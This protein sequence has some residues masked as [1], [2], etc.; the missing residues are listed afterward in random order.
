M[1]L[2]FTNGR[3]LLMLGL[4]T[5]APLFRPAAAQNAPA[6]AEVAKPNRGTG[7][8]T[9]TV[10]N[11]AT[12]QPV[13][14]ANVGLIDVATNK[15]I[16]GG[17]CDEKGR[18]I[19]SNIGAG[20]YKLNV[21][22]VGF[23]AKVMEH[24]VFATADANVDLGNIS[25]AA[26]AQQ[27]S[28][29]KVVGEREL[30]E[31]KIDRIV[32]NADKD[33]TNNGGTAADVL[34]K[35]PLLSVDIDGNLQLRGSGNIRVLVNGKPSTILANNLAD[36]LRQ[37]PADQIKSV[38][39]ITSPSSKYD[40]EGTAGVVNIILKKSNL[41]GVNGSVNG[42]ASNRG[43]FLSSTV[44][45]RRGKLGLNTN[46]GTNMF[47]NV[48]RNASVRTEFLPTEGRSTLQQSGNFTNLG[49]GAFAQLGIEYDLT[50]KDAFNI[51]GRGNLFGYTNDRNQRT[52]YIGPKVN[53]IFTRDIVTQ[54]QN[55]NFDLNFGYTRTM[56]KP[57][58]ELSVLALYSQN[59]GN[60]D[61]DLDQRR[62][63]FIDYHE[64]SSNDNR[65]REATLQLDYIQPVDS[66]GTLELGLKSILRRVSS[67]YL[68]ASD[69]LDGRGL[70]PIP[71]RSNAFRYDQNVY[72]TYAT[73]SFALG[74][75]LT[76]KAGTRVEH[77]RIDGDFITD[78]I[79]LR[80]DYTNVVPS[81][82][83]AY[84]LNKDNKLK[85]SYTRRIQRPGIWFLNPYVNLS[86][87]R[88]ISSGNPK[89]DPELTDAYEL[90]YSTFI[91]KSTI[92][93]SGYFRQTNNAIESVSRL[94]PSNTVLPTDDTTRVLYS[95][96]LNVARNA[97]YGLSAFGST[98]ITPKWSLNGNI[99]VYY[100]Q[101]R[102]QALGLSNGGVMYNGN[103]TSSWTFD[104]GWSA[105]FSGLFNS[106][107]VA[108]QGRTPGYRTYT[109]AAKK[110]LFNKKASLTLGV[111][112]PFNR[113]LVF[114][115]QLATDRF[116]FSNNSY[117][118]NRQ[119]RLSF[120]YQFGKLDTKPARPK[121]SIRND[122]Q[123][124][125]DG[126]NG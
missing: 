102:S 69:S 44:N 37:I 68:V 17:T 109:L 114:R 42:A 100:L 43:A 63:E 48:A 104:K 12:N 40:A 55:T 116:D 111:V 87:R 78:N 124:Q 121:K 27:L 65:N 97:T 98:K 47:Y 82:Q 113:K 3:S 28:E 61:Y 33:I 90:A 74:K 8:L 91:N 122:D 119:I 29:V 66:T 51:S 85:L 15:A 56:A 54:E 7:R 72:S 107:R 118:Y 46:A 38:E 71:S 30:V 49:G 16:G 13:E 59:K 94:V 126:G 106:R 88:N 1:K 2:L 64:T 99:N 96:F 4:L 35:A 120:N 25:L 14:F 110:E 52:A 86:D 26:A 41:E 101:L 125:G 93:F 112:N 45:T 103:L 10:I 115:S 24:V 81:V 9:G 92:N 60:T 105:Q 62:E 83:A 95:T 5:T 19:L 53:D 18:F 58:Q 89:V 117:F 32:Y 79:S 75:K 34:Q 57:K 70:L 84:D 31:N 80:T 6:T 36:A 23:Q 108:L 73:Y 39:V 11:A 21:S 77:T 67:D 20:T 76:L 22:F 50:P 123:K